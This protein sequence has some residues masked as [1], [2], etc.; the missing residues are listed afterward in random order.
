MQIVVVRRVYV[1]SAALIGLL[2]LAAGLRTLLRLLL[3]TLFSPPALGLAG[4][5]TRVSLGSALVLVGGLLWA[6]HWWWAQRSLT[7]PDER[8]SA[9]RRLYGYL[10]LGI[11][12]LR[13]LFAAAAL[14]ALA[15]GAPADDG[16]VPAQL[17][18][19]LV[20]GV[21]WL[22]HWRVLS[23]DRILV[24]TQG[25][26]ATLRRWYLVV[27]QAVSLALIGFNAVQLL[28]LTLRQLLPVLA[29]AHAGAVV[30]YPL[31][32][33]LAGMAV[34]LPHHR[35]ALDLVQR[36]SPLQPDEAR[37][38]LRQVYGAL[39]VSV[40]ALSALSAL[41]ALLYHVLLA[42][43]GAAGTLADALEPLAAALISLPLW[44][45]HRRVLLL[46]GALG[47]PPTRAAVAR[48]IN[49]Y[50]LA[51]IGLLGVFV[52]L[53]TLLTN[54]LRLWLLPAALG[55][56]WQRG[57]SLGLALTL[58]ALPVYAVTSASLEGWA[59]REPAEERTLARRIYL[60]GALLALLV[61]VIVALV[62]LLQELLARALGAAE[63]NTDLSPVIS[64]LLVGLPLL[65]SYLRLLRRAQTARSA[66]EAQLR[67]ALLV[68][69]EWAA[70][71]AA[72]L[73]RELPGVQ[74][75]VAAPD[76]ATQIAAA[77]NGAEVLISSLSAPRYAPAAAALST[78]AGR[79]LV[80]VTPL[81]EAELIG[82]PADPDALARA[83]VRR[84]R[85]LLAATPTAP[86]AAPPAAAPGTGGET[87][88]P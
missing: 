55:E 34:W 49:G 22:Y 32:N 23:A 33:L 36:A 76:D 88:A 15:L 71:L 77:L 85:E 70:P 4:A 75:Q 42:L 63:P 13:L 19:L 28:T 30:A 20:D 60:Y 18:T 24:E 58:V 21:I 61:T 64:V 2:M 25:A 72:A 52:G 6:G 8:A 37:S 79:R 1:Y 43:F 78:F 81:P 5:A 3:E 82:A 83:L 41:T 67:A 65:G 38:T 12:M 17:A 40:T 31:A 47:T 50:L 59:R 80:L 26:P 51:A 14:L 69:P 7:Q 74:L 44:W 46:E 48:R 68:E 87:C 56:G 10:V 53:A 66:T 84:L 11:T 45:Y 62:A 16:R 57:L 29:V 86:P 9:L 35:W 39:V 27:I 54:L 73:R